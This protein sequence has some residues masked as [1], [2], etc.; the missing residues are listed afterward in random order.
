MN[1]IKVLVV[2]T[3]FL[4]LVGCGGGAAKTSGGSGK[5]TAP[6]AEQAE[7]LNNA[8]DA[9]ESAEKAYYDKKLE[10]IELEQKLEDK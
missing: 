6:T 7:R 10:R 3:A 2:V 1:F 5:S 4:F 9:A 8:Q